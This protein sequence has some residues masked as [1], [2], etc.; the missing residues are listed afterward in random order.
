L[1]KGD[2]KEQAKERER[3]RERERGGER[4]GERRRIGACK[5]TV[6]A[7]DLNSSRFT[8]I[9]VQKSVPP[10]FA[11][12]IATSVAI[13]AFDNDVALV[14][15]SMDSPSKRSGGTVPIFG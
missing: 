15:S 2:E 3:E 7:R 8:L 9:A 11:R 12:V 13:T 1:E 14:D 4:K 5:S 10:R 6:K